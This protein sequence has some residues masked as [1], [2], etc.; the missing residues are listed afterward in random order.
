M[1]ISSYDLQRL[2]LL[3]FPV[4]LISGPL[5]PELIILITIFIY[6]LKNSSN[7]IRR[8]FSNKIFLFLL[9]FTFYIFLVGIISFNSQ[10]SIISSVF[11]FR[12]PLFSIIFF[13][14]LSS[15]SKFRKFFLYVL[16]SI[17]I[18]LFIDAS[19]QSIFK[20][21][22]FGTELVVLRASSLFGDELILGSYTLKLSPIL[23]GLLFIYYKQINKFFILLIPASM[24]T[25]ILSGERSAFISSLIF[26]LLIIYLVNFEKKKYLVSGII[27]VFL[28]TFS[29]QVFKERFIYD[30][31]KKFIFGQNYFYIPYEYS[32]FV[33][34]SIEQF[35]N[36][37]IT[38]GG[39]RSFRVNCKET[40]LKID[41]YNPNLKNTQQIK[42]IDHTVKGKCSTHPHNLILEFASELGVIGLIFIIYKFYFLLKNFMF[43]YRKNKMN[44]DLLNI[45]N[46]I[47]ILSP[48]IITFPFLPSGSFFNNWNLS[49]YFLN[50]AFLM[51]AISNKRI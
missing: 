37:P 10:K 28:T 12:F 29:S 2:L 48:I 7:E 22:L 39:I 33:F 35:K 51:Y 13:K 15:D 20:K 30:L 31:E 16:I 42:F 32:G 26:V 25:I 38:G 23:F 8:D 34:S 1:S 47:F 6:F 50:I 5:I 27:I 36:N 44:Y 21:N 46:M 11:F 17:F 9:I 19:I 49:I 4:A 18:F 43:C 3:A 40:L 45:S 24:V 41:P 14:Y